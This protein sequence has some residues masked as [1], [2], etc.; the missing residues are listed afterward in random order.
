MS[1]KKAAEILGVSV[2]TIYRMIEQ[3]ILQPTKT[4]GGQRRF[5]VSQLNEFRDKSRSI[6]APQNPSITRSANKEVEDI[7]SEEQDGQILPVESEKPVDP[8]NPL[9]DLNGS[10][11][12]PETKS[13]FLPKRIRG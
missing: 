1:T 6:V 9:N 11:W 13:F 12:L 10:Q 4:P 5:D 8:R 3:D 7:E 2:S